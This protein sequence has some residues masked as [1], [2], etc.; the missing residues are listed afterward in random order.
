MKISLLPVSQYPEMNSM[1]MSVSE[2]G[3]FLKEAGFDGMDLGM[4]SIFAH[5]PRYLKQLKDEIE[6]SGLELVM[7]S[8]YPDFTHPNP[9]QRKREEA[10]FANDIAVASQLG[11]KY[12][13]ILSGQVHEGT[14]R[15]DGIN[16]AVDSFHKMDEIAKELGVVLVFEN[17]SR[18]GAWFDFDFG[19]PTD[20]FLEIYEKTMDTNIR[21]NFDTMNTLYYGED[22]LPLLKKIYPRLETIHAN[23]TAKKGELIPCLLGEGAADFVE[24]FTYLKQQGFDGWICIEEISGT[25]TSAYKKTYDF[26]RHTWDSITV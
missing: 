25:G 14:S 23:D 10:Y 17:H 1:K 9:L 18:P 20:V 21:I 12:V 24:I 26:V 16:W 7:I 22:S 11:A 2:F 19:W 5:Y 6:G 13:R 4:G 15:K 8:T 3:R